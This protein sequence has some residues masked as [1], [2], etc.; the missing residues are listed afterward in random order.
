MA[1]ALDRFINALLLGG[2]PNQTVSIN[3]AIARRDGKVWGCILCRW[4]DWTIEVAHCDKALNDTDTSPAAGLKALL[5]LI[6]INASIY[7]SPL[8]IHWIL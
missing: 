8:I 1:L 6:I 5:Q 3:A 7:Y 4:F 2:T